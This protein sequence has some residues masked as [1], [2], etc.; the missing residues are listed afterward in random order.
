MFESEVAVCY[1]VARFF[2]GPARSEAGAGLRVDGEPEFAG[3]AAGP[4]VSGA[5]VLGEEIR[6]RR[7]GGDGVGVFAPRV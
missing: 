7:F 3:R 1:F 4:A 6:R 2:F 5:D